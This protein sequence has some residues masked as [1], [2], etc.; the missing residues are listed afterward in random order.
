MG[1]FV[2]H[3]MPNTAPVAGEES[4]RSLLELPDVCLLAV[5]QC[6]AADYCT[7]FTAARAHSRLSQAAVLA[8]P[9]VQAVVTEQQVDSVLLYLAKYGSRDD[10]ICLE[11]P[12]CCSDGEHAASLQQLP[13]NLQLSSMQLKGFKLQLQ[14]GDGFQ[15]VLGAAQTAAALKQLRLCSCDVIDGD[16]LAQLPAGLEHLSI[17][18]LCSNRNTASFPTIVL[19]QLQQLTY[20]ELAGVRVQRPDQT[21]PTLQPVQAL[22]RLVDLRLAG[23]TA[24][25][26]PITAGMLSSLHSLTRLDLVGCWFQPGVLS[27]KTLLQHLNLNYWL[28]GVMTL[29]GVQQLLS[30]L[31]PL[32]QLTHLSLRGTMGASNVGGGPPAAP[33]SALTASSKL[34]H[35]DINHCALPAGLWQHLFPTS[36]QLPHLTS[37]NI[38]NSGS[39]TAPEGTRLVS[40][41]PGL[42]SLDLGLLRYSVELLAPL[43]GLS[44]LQKLAVA[45]STKDTVEGLQSVCHLTRLKELELV[46]TNLADPGVLLQMTQLKQ[47]TRLEYHGPL[48]PLRHTDQTLVAQVGP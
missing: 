23:V 10:R 34:Q 8:L 33:Y 7:L 20:L 39:A 38:A 29:W 1:P 11:G 45:A 19:E 30:H 43:Q 42:R 27:G 13:P 22:T 26:A 21:K 31:Q 4:P 16:A 47:L 18:T 37:L 44:G 17:D 12:G 14:P 25:G 3:R 24:P 36:R 32:H 35:L 40:C 48:S 15:G 5:L 28:T 9:S 6:C 41:C 46:I 2:L